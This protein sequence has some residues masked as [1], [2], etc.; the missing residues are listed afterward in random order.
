LERRA[1]PIIGS[2]K[3]VAVEIKDTAFVR[4]GNF[5]VFIGDIN[6]IFKDD[7]ADVANFDLGWIVGIGRR[8]N[9][10]LELLECVN[11]GNPFA[12]VGVEVDE[13][14]KGRK[15]FSWL[16]RRHG[17][18]LGVWLEWES[19]VS[20]DTLD[21]CRLLGRLVGRLVSWIITD[22]NVPERV[23]V[24]RVWSLTLLELDDGERIRGVRAD[25]GLIY[26]LEHCR[27]ANV[28]IV[29]GVALEINWR[30]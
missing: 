23:V 16:E 29:L 17:G 9:A 1:G 12:F 7:R 6:D 4:A 24:L 18:W 14:V 19:N 22:S 13:T 28:L 15:S 25:V 20:A 10:A 3:R 5:K 30:Y 2:H 21:R 11:E 27:L 8:G 26:Q